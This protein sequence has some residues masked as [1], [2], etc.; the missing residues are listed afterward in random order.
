MMICCVRKVTDLSRIWKVLEHQ[1]YSAKA[2]DRFIK[3]RIKSM[4]VTDFGEF[5][6]VG[7]RI[8]RIAGRQKLPIQEF[9]HQYQCHQNKRAQRGFSLDGWKSEETMQ[10]NLRRFS[11]LD[12][13]IPQPSKMKIIS[14][15]YSRIVINDK[16]N[17]S[18]VFAKSPVTLLRCMITSNAEG[19]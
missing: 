12:N 1:Y 15:I 16:Q 9:C 19:R 11:F 17:L 7:G 8:E 14:V 6:G 5:W 2:F 18:W 13:A 10:H 3:I 4:L